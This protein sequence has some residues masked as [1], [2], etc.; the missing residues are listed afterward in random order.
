ML[1]KV[2]V[3][4]RGAIA[5]RIFRTLR[6]MGIP[7]VAVYSEPDAGALFVGGADE[8]EPVALAARRE[9][10]VLGEEAVP[11]MNG[12]GTG[13]ACGVEQPVDRQVGFRARRWTDAHGLV[14]LGDVR[15]AG[16]GVGVDRHPVD[17]HRTERPEHAPGDLATVGH[18]DLTDARHGG[19]DY[20]VPRPT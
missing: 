14:G 4:N 1:R 7:S 10:G 17:A 12:V 5:L 19:P 13:R 3:A 9:V 16:I 8:G 18:E 11:G 20:G 15:C 2:L 6:R